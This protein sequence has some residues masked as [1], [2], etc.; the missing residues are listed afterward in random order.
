MMQSFKDVGIPWDAVQNGY[1]KYTS[2]INP[3]TQVETEGYFS[4]KEMLT[5]A[6][7]ESMYQLIPPN[8]LKNKDKEEAKKVIQQVADRYGKTYENLVS[9]Q[10]SWYE[11]RGIKISK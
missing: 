2:E 3:V 5:A 9:G 10:E 8:I 4:I 1:I 7:S 11:S 6:D